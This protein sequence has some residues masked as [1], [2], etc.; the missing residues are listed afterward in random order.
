MESLNFLAAWVRSTI[1]FNLTWKLF[2]IG[3]FLCSY[4]KKITHDNAEI[5]K[6]WS[7]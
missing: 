2:L 4:E 5:G 1:L 3:N 7:E 6:S